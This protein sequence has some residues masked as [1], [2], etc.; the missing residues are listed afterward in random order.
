M[1]NRKTVIMNNST[2]IKMEGSFMKRIITL[3]LLTT[4][5]S[6]YGSEQPQEKQ[7]SP[8][9]ILLAAIEQKST[10]TQT[11][12]TDRQAAE[13]I[14]KQ[15]AEEI[16]PAANMLQPIQTAIDHSTTSQETF[17]QIAALAEDPPY[18]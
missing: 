2:R 16:K 4:T 7:P 1:M 18:N 13:V 15:E 12:N 3:V 17:T 10:D 9:A 8:F 5:L 14:I 11:Q 6:L